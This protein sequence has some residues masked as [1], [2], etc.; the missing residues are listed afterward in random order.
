MAHIFRE[1]SAEEESQTLSSTSNH[2][3]S[4][5]CHMNGLQQKPAIP[6]S[7]EKETVTFPN[8]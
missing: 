5:H 2:S 1:S 8:L 6:A 3:S 4:L 7:S